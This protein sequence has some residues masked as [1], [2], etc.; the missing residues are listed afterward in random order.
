MASRSRNLMGERFGPYGLWKVPA[1]WTDR[2]ST[3]PWTS[4]SD[5]HTFRRPDGDGDGLRNSIGEIETEHVRVRVSRFRFPHA[6]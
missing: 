4:P 6:L 5:V 2:P 3:E 1:R